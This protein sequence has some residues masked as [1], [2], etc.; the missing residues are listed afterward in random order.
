MTAVQHRPDRTSADRREAQ[1][2]EAQRRKAQRRE[3]EHREPERREPERRELERR[4]SV[5]A[6]PE[7]RA[8]RLSLPG[9]A[10]EQLRRAPATVCYLIAVWV[11]GLATGSI[12]HGPPRWL[13]GH[14]A[15]GLPSLGH[16]YWWTPLSASLWASGLGSYLAI[17]AL[18]LLVLG[19]AEHRMGITR[20]FT[21]L[22][23]SQAAAVLLACGL[24]EL[25]GLARGP[26]P[27]GLDGQT[28]VGA[29]PGMLGV[30]FALSCTLTP[31]WRRR[32]RLLLT[33]AS[34]V[35]VM[36]IGHLDQLALAC[37]AVSGLTAVALTYDRAWPWTG[38]R[39]SRHEVRVLVAALVAVPALGA[40]LAALGASAHGP[41]T[42]PSLLFAPWP[43]VP[44]QAAPALLLLLCAYGLRRGRRLAWWLAVVMNLAVLGVSVWVAY[45]LDSSRAVR[46]PRAGGGPRALLP[47]RELPARE[48]MLLSV[49]TLL[50]LL[51]TR[52]R[53]DQT[54]DGRAARRLAATLAGALA[55][56]CGAFLLFDYLLGPR[57]GSRAAAGAL[58]GDLPM[59]FLAVMLFSDR[60]TPGGL[61]GRLLYVWV[62]LLFWIVVLA[63]LAAFFL[64]TSAYRDADA[65]DRA[66]AILTRGGST[67]SYMSTW[68]GNAYSFSPD[69]RAAIAYRVI[70]GVAITVG[71]P[72]GDPAAF[73]SAITEFAR[74][75]EHRSLHPC[76]YSVTAR[77]LEVTQRLGWKSVHIAE[78]NL[79]P[80]GCLEFAGKKWQNVR[81][82]MNKAT[83][84]GITAQWWSYPEMPLELVRQVHQIS[85][86]W[87]ADKGLPEMN[88]M[89]GGLAELNDPDIRCLVALGPDRTLLAITSWL[90]VY[91]SGRPAGWTLDLMRRNTAP[92]TFHGVMEFLIATAALTFQEEGASFVSLAGAPLARLD[93]GEQ[94][95]AVQRVL[96]MIASTMEPAYGFASLRVFKAKF[97][98]V[99]E[100]LYLTYPDPAAL[101]AIAIAISRAYLP[102]LTSRQGLRLLTKIRRRP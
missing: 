21:T 82:A 72:F 14:V 12:S 56:S 80:L 70:G 89:L 18:G 68:P 50:V 66:R 101:G 97:Q 87:V 64:H 39:A 62:F 4:E 48:A 43:G 46:I 49:V 32:L 26:W 51:V 42:L 59:R 95:C 100:P 71:E 33:V 55:V 5:P 22:L 88:F 28:A 69:G 65:A 63:A 25:A 73:D 17:T 85:A 11:A 45:A 52:R 41:M 53:F 47:A 29:A 7:R 35:S 27:S 19:P 16:G 20:T 1:L 86:K 91:D 83:R 15:A 30:G 75:C 44:V 9:L 94:P 90:P 93:R 40:V 74:I 81:N 76:L 54:A 36:Y 84:E 23:V 3:L 13:A 92:G 6:L 10:W 61:L 31:L 58:P 34:T 77:T 2:R 99:Y 60:F 79:V 78:D 102:H 24:I 37:G 98:P 8:G 67:L 96:D 38:L 57:R